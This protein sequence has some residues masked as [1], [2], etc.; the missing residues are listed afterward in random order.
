M[1]LSNTLF[2][3]W[4]LQI[5]AVSASFVG[6]FLNARQDV[7]GFR[8]WIFSSAILLAIHVKSRLWVLCGSDV[9]Y[10]G[11][12]LQGIHVWKTKPIS[13]A[14]VGISEV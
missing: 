11:I 14:G 6:A 9:I 1:N 10:A 8:I 12:C 5:A 2:W 13:P 7:R 3:N 4:A